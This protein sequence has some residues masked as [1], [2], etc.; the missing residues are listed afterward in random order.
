MPTLLDLPTLW[1][2]SARTMAV[3]GED[4]PTVQEAATG[5]YA[6]AILGLTEEECREAK[7]ADHI[8]NKTL[9][10]CLA[11]VRALP[12]EESEKLLTGVMMI[13]YADRSMKPLEVRWASMLASAIG[14]S[15]DVF[16]RCCVNARII[17]SML[18]PS[19]GAA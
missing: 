4:L 10:D 5:L 2:L 12:T 13:A 6:Q 8:S 1:F 18:R 15:P 19:G 9:I 17:A 11:G 14:V 7:D 3:A 16:Q